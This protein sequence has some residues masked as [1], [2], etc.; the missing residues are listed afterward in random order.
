MDKRWTFGPGQKLPD[1]EEVGTSELTESR[2]SEIARQAAKEVVEEAELPLHIA[3]HVATGSGIVVDEAKAETTP[4]KTFKFEDTT[5]GWSPGIVGLISEKRN[6]EQ[7]AKYCKSRIPV[8]DGVAKRFAR[9]KES[10]KEA[11]KEW[12]RQG[13]GLA[14]WWRKVAPALETK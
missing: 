14:E 8:S 2:V 10:V 7:F 9:V 11:H 1:S 3:E 6:P 12:E 5:Y 4:C 13:G